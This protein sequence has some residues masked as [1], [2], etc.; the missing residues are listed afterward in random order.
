MKCSLRRDNKR[1]SSHLYLQLLSFVLFCFL[2]SKSVASTS[3]ELANENATAFQG[4]PFISNFNAKVYNA[5]GQNWVAV[6]DRRGVMYFGNT[7]GILEFDGQRWQTVPTSGSPMVRSLALADDGTIFYGSIGDFGYLQ[8]SPSGK[9]NAVSLRD[10]LSKDE[11][12]FND[13][14]QILDT[15]QGVVFLTRSR[16]FRFYQ[17]TLSAIKGRFASSQATVLNG[18][19]FF[20]DIDNGISLLDG[21]QVIPIP[22][23]ADI[24]N[25]KRVMLAAFG[26]HEILVGRLSVSPP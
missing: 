22:Q 13:V 17:G 5:H 2:G 7:S 10:K 20:A 9:V 6:Q 24:S 12:E 21:D 15:K 25:G 16:I 19:L 4:T 3:P 14:W 8:A 1:Y 18:T 11:L 26:T 23:L